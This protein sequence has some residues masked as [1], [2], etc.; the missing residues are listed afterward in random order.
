METNFPLETLN[1]QVKLEKLATEL[2]LLPCSFLNKIS[3]KLIQIISAKEVQDL[4]EG[5]MVLEALAQ[6]SINHTLDLEKVSRMVE[7]AAAELKLESPIT[8]TSLFSGG[9]KFIREISLNPSWT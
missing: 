4:Y 9:G 5:R 7:T 1:R 6:P 3:D 2:P 8:Y